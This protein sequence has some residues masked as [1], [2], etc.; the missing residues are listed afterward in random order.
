MFFNFSENLKLFNF[1]E[2]KILQFQRNQNS[3]IFRKK[4]KI[5]QRIEILRFPEKKIKIFSKF[6]KFAQNTLVESFEVI[7]SRGYR[8]ISVESFWAKRSIEKW[9]SFELIESKSIIFER[10]MTNLDQNPQSM[11]NRLFHSNRKGNW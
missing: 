7:A 11:L 1:G 3:S 5:L 10:I 2:I 8:V 6:S 4:I 9:W